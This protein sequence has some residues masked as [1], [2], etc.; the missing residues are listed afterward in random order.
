MCLLQYKTDFEKC[1]RN[2]I[3]MH[4]MKLIDH[5]YSHSLDSIKRLFIV[6]LLLNYAKFDQVPIAN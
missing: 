1:L 5:F 2:L 4:R 3:V 6:L